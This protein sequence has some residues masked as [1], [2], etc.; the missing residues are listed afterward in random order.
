MFSSASELPLFTPSTGHTYFL[1][2]SKSLTPGISSQATQASKETTPMPGTQDM[3]FSAKPL[4]SSKLTSDPDDQSFPLL[5]EAYSLSVRYGKEYMDDNPLVGEPGSFILSKSRELAAAPVIHTAPKTSAMSKRPPAP[6]IKT[7]NLTGTA[8]K[9]SKG[10]EKS[11]IS[12]LNKD[13]KARRKSKAANGSAT[14]EIGPGL[15]TA[16]SL[17]WIHPASFAP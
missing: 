6:E 17:N 10:A 13:R 5:L 14:A 9:G 12:P 7:T 15:G 1:P 11:P 8:R 4:L 2:A 16:N 3:S